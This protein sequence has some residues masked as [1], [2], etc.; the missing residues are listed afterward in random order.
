MGGAVGLGAGLVW[1]GHGLSTAAS[2][3]GS[4]VTEDRYYRSMAKLAYEQA[5]QI[6]ANAR[7]N[8]QY[9]FEDAAYQNSQLA[10][11]YARLLGEQKTTLAANGLNTRSETVQRILKNSRLNE[12]MDQELLEQNMQRAIFET[13]TQ[14]SLEAA[15]YRTQAKQYERI[16]RNKSGWFARV[17]T[18]LNSILN[19]K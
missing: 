10:Q 7:R 18:A 2:V 14:A 17:G 8:T 13:N 5:D 9:I 16:R 11:D 3:I 19:W 4:G 1:V 6:E 12:E 15:Q